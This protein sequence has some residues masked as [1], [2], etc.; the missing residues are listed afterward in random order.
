MIL[1]TSARKAGVALV[2]AL[3]TLSLVL[4]DGVTGQEW[5]QVAVATLGALG[6]YAVS[7]NKTK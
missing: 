6:V 4:Q 1:L 5:I 7:N 3:T 2:T